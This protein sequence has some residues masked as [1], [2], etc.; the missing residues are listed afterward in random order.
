MPRRRDDDDDDDDADVGNASADAIDAIDA[1]MLALEETTAEVFHTTCCHTL[2][3][4]STKLCMSMVIL[5]V[6]HMSCIVNPYAAS[7]R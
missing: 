5:H 6:R 7:H 3:Q 2:L 4:H 1:P